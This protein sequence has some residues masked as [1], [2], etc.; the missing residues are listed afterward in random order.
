[1]SLTITRV[2]SD[3]WGK[4]RAVVADVTF[5]SSYPAG[6]E[7]VAKEALGMRTVVEGGQIVGGNAAAAAYL[8]HFVPSTRKMMLMY[9]TG[10]ANASPAALADPAGTQ[11]ASTIPAGGT[12]VTS[13]AANGAIVT[14]PNPALTPGKGKEL[15]A[16]TDAST[17]TFRVLFLGR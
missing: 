14:N 5:D 4:T 10:G 7:L 8:A 3:V 9:P 12:P 11:A 16:T 1:M 13:T 6:G 17:L 2:R 15:L